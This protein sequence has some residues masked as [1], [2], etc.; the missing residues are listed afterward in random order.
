MLY[1]GSTLVLLAASVP[2]WQG[3]AARYS[4]AETFGGADFFDNFVFNSFNDPTHGFVD[5]Q[6]RDA[7]FGGGFAY[8][9]DKGQAVMRADSETVP[10]AWQRGRR[11]VRITSK[12]NYSKGLFVFDAEHIPAS[13]CGSWPAYW[14][15]GTGRRWPATGEIDIIEYVNKGTRNAGTVHT[16][17]GCEAR[18]NASGDLWTNRCGAN[19][20][21]VGCGWKDREGKY[22]GDPVNEA[23]GAV[24]VSEWDFEAERPI[25]LWSFLRN[26]VPQDILEDN[27]QPWTWKKPFA[28]WL[29]NDGWCPK[30]KFTGQQFIINTTF[31]GDWAGGVWNNGCA[32]ET[33]YSS[34]SEYVRNNPQAYKDTYWTVNHLKIFQWTGAE[35]NPVNIGHG[36]DEP[37]PGPAPKCGAPREG[38]A[39][40]GDI[41][42]AMD[43]GRFSNPEWYATFHEFVD[44]W[45]QGDNIGD[46]TVEDFQMYF[47]CNPYFTGKSQNCGRPVCGRRCKNAPPTPEPTASPPEPEESAEE[48]QPDCT[49]ADQDRWGPDLGGC[50]GGLEERSEPRP[51]DDEWFCP[52]G[53]ADHGRTCW[54]TRQM[55]R[56]PSA[57][58]SQCQERTRKECD[59]FESCVWSKR[60]G[61]FSIDGELTKKQRKLVCKQAKTVAACDATKFCKSMVKRDTLKKC[62]P[63]KAAN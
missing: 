42:W 41:N 33:G 39:C 7:A 47:Y 44:G 21:F 50:C 46:A 51:A 63:A 17:P 14:S 31:C 37:L 34:C 12:K 22:A 3:A 9:N 61:C 30:E 32:Q 58:D 38:D 45:N 24:Y 27:P 2:W 43:T 15:N 26:E 18:G 6:T 1:G 16:S 62:K 60:E 29:L 54:S 35:E 28:E 13:V 11:S 36:G 52:A 56:D 5:Y 8:I 19:G 23:G 55:C 10:Q 4:I 57:G 59:G 48:E 49:G 20:G 53:D 40:V 25:R